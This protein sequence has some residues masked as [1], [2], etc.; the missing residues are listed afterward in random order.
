MATAAD[1]RLAFDKQRPA[2][3]EQRRHQRPDHEP[4]RPNTDSR[5]GSRSGSGSP[6][7]WCPCPPDR[8]QHVVH[9][10]DHT[11]TPNNPSTTPCQVAPVNRK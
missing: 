3:H 6:A 4:L 9:Q 7:S 11:N 8:A 10:A 5:P 2:R 1:P